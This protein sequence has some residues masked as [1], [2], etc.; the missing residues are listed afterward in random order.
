MDDSKILITG[1][2]GQ[3]GLA[4]RAKYPRARATDVAELDITDE[5]KVK[6][7]D[8][9]DVKVIINAAGY[10]NVDGA[11]TPEGEKLAR[12]INAEAVGNLAE[13]AEQNKLLLIHI[14]TAYVFDGSK[15]IYTEDDGPNPLGKYA[16]SKLAGDRKAVGAPKHYIVRTDSVIGEGK[17]FVRTMLGLGQK[18]VAPTVVAD[19]IIRPTFT[20]VL[21][22]AIGFLLDK[23]PPFGIYNVT[24][25]GEAVSWADFTRA[26]FKEAGMNLS[27]T[28]TTLAEYSA[29]KPGIAPRPLNSVLD[30]SKIE[31]AG[32]KPTD[33]RAD[34][35]EYI[36]KEMK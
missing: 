21:A 24:N 13:V 25:E 11:E 7:F 36:E 31:V 35:K 30:L 10:T 20:T 23:S 6:N 4:L 12:A 33:W 32:F 18:G 1:G 22:E 9:S 26:I 17:N 14:S 19:Q 28:N 27:V 15:K 3:L 29:G 16:K 5:Q 34:L 8:W 2:N